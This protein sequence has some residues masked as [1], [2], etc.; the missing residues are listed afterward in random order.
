M[1]LKYQGLIITIIGQGNFSFHNEAIHPQT[2]FCCW[3][4]VH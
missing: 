4:T 2:L 1:F 3:K